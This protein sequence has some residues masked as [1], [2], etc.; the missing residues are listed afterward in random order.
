VVKVL[1]GPTQQGFI[2]PL[3]ILFELGF[4]TKCRPASYSFYPDL[5]IDISSSASI[6]SVSNLH[7]FRGGC[8]RTNCCD[9]LIQSRSVNFRRMYFCGGVIECTVL[10]STYCT[11]V[12]L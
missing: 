10:V 3:R 7:Q 11:A 12:L 4:N 5:L 8:V 6:A 9:P 2:F 1:I